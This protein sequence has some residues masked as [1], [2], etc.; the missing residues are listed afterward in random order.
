MERDRI[1]VDLTDLVEWYQQH[2]TVSGIQRVVQQLCSVPDVWDRDDVVFVYRP[3]PKSSFYRL[4][5]RI[6]FDL[7]NEERVRLSVH[8]LRDMRGAWPL[9]HKIHDLYVRARKQ[10]DQIN[11][12]IKKNVTWKTAALAPLLPLLPLLP[13]MR[14]LLLSD[15]KITVQSGDKVFI[16]GAF[17]VFPDASDFYRTLS[18]I[19]GVEVIAILYDLI[20][21]SHPYF[22]H[23]HLVEEFE[24]QIKKVLA[25]CSRFFAISEY[26][27]DDFLRFMDANGY[28]R[29]PVEVMSFGFGLPPI[30]E[31]PVKDA[32]SLK[33][34]GLEQDRFALVV[35]TLEPRKNPVVLL[36][37]WK[38]LYEKYGDQTP[39]LVFVG[40]MGW[41]IEWF[42]DDL[43]RVNHL[44]QLVRHHKGV[45]DR[46]LS[47]LYRRADVV[48]FPSFA[49][50]WGLPVEEAVAYG[51]HVLASNATSVPEAGRDAAFYFDPLDAD[52]IVR[53]VSHCLD[54]ENYLA[55]REAIVSKRA[56]KWSQEFTWKRSASGVLRYILERKSPRFHDI[57]ADEMP[58]QLNGSVIPK[59]ALGSM[60]TA[61]LSN[62]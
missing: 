61:A 16:T 13:L 49:E 10:P 6:I 1:L 24:G 47:M 15:R 17:W 44:N 59:E 14:R 27:R 62:P 43:R 41:K 2:N 11:P 36:D 60:P 8:R 37:A 5:K 25:I 57:E 55:E 42:F 45:R 52:A 50:G 18:K 54:D 23:E 51:K 58:S 34:F 26:V 35:G 56:E 3:G 31:D 20:P 9:R 46:D 32:K 53:E 12:W 39:K 29:K 48:L 30:K 38:K 4:D 22:C 7:V 33:S 40:K 19:D 28:D 21:L